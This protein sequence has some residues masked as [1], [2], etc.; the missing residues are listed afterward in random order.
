MRRILPFVA[1]AALQ[2][3]LVGEARG[4][5]K[6]RCISASE[7]GQE[8]RDDGNYRRA[9]EAFS[10]CARESCPPLV[11][12]D[13]A[14][15][16]ADLEE[17]WPSVILSVKDS[18]G[19][20][21][22]NV[23]VLLDGEPF[24]SRLDGKPVRVDPG[25]HVLRCEAD[26]YPA[27]EQRVVVRAGE[28]NRMVDVRL[29]SASRQ[30]GQLAPD[31]RVAGAGAADDGARGHSEST[32][33]LG[34]RRTSALVFGALAVAAF[35]TEAY[36]GLT[37]LSDRNDLMAQPCAQTSTCP[38]S[39]VDAIRMKFTVADISLG[40]GVVST[41]LA[42]YLF[43]SAPGSEPNMPSAR[44]DFAPVPGGGGATFAGAF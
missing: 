40:V 25:E 3:L 39:A 28:K 37:G 14:H 27:A 24:A 32:H 30:T 8:L 5:E 17:T 2:A 6:Q 29:G 35:G 23:R 10:A 44:V 34:G 7:E 26:G 19:R 1:V 20:D 41:I 18:G 13:C 21:L 11:R 9:R 43:F 15:W 33:G 16:Q 38:P 36:F 31:G 12:R 4:N 22:S 42:A